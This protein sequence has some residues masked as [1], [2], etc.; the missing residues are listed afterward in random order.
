MAHTH[1]YRIVANLVMGLPDTEGWVPQ[2]IVRQCRDCP[3][4]ETLWGAENRH[5]GRNRLTGWEAW[6]D[7]G[8]Q[9]GSAEVQWKPGRPPR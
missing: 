8:Y 1:H 4:T 9:S 3:L 5:L 6:T 2:L 7:A